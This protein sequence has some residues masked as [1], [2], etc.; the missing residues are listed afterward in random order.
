LMPGF[1][2]SESGIG[3]PSALVIEMSLNL[4]TS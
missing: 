4:L 2:L 3:L 1:V